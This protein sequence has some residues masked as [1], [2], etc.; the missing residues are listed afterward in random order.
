MLSVHESRAAGLA[1]AW[2]STGAAGSAYGLPRA[3]ILAD[4][5]AGGTLTTGRVAVGGS[6]TGNLEALLDHDWFAVD[7]TAGRTYALRQQGNGLMDPVL[8]LRS[9]TGR[10]LALNDDAEGTRNSLITYKP[11]VSGRYFLDAA[12]Y[13]DS[14]LGLYTVSVTDVTPVSVAPVDDFAAS[15]ATTGRLAMGGSSGGNLEVNGDHDWFQVA[16]QAGRSYAFRMTGAGLW[17][18]HLRLRSQTGVQLAANDD[19]EGTRNSLINFTATANATLY[20]DAGAFGETYSGTYSVSALDVTPPPPTGY[21]SSDGY[22]E[23]SAARALDRLTGQPLARAAALGGLAW[24]LDRVGAP[25][26]WAAGFTGAGITVA[27]IDSGVDA[28]HPDL[29]ANIWI[30]PGEIAGN[31]LDDDANGYIDDINGWDFVGNDNNPMDANGHG[32]HVAGTIA[33]ENNGVGQT[34]VAPNARIMPVRVLDAGGSGSYAA[35]AAGIRYAANNGARVINLS[36]GGTT[37]DDA[38]LAAVRDAT[39]LGALVVMAAGNSGTATPAFPA[40]YAREVGLAIGAVDSAGTLARF[41]NRAGAT[42]LD[43]VTAPGVSVYSTLPGNTYGSLSGT[44]M[45]APHAAGVA[46]LLLSA[47]PTLTPAEIES[48]LTATASHGPATL[49]T[50]VAT[51]SGSGTTPVVSALRPRP[52]SPSPARAG[53]S[54]ALA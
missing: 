36:L 40:V 12:S 35:I 15:S 18:P 32:T 26:A 54:S 28:L 39:S 31:G 44:S 51:T 50:P 8:R 24:G 38:L 30:N 49:A 14:L 17:D 2:G 46:A 5:Y 11:N 42:P 10:Q 6:S 29:D 4:D 16:V 48:L 1:A 25:T 53:R 7:L 45:A 27:V 33:A 21:S 41:S 19:A 9:S 3:G 37:G 47:S 20:L 22:G 23:V 43:Y 52:W 13:R 34:G